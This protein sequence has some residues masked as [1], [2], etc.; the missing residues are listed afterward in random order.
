MSEKI[1]PLFK[2]VSIEVLTLILKKGVRFTQPQAF[3]DPFEF[4]PEM[5]IPLDS[6]G[7]QLNIAFDLAAP[8]RLPAV[9][10]EKDIPDGY[11]CSDIHSRHIVEQLNGIVGVLC[12]SRNP[13]SLLMWAHYADRYKGALIEFD[14]EDPFFEGQ[15]AVEYCDVRPR[16]NVSAYGAEGTMPLAELCVKSDKWEY[17]AEVRIIRNLSACAEKGSDPLYPVYV[18]QLPVNAI[19]EITLGE[20]CSVE[21]QRVIWDLVK[22]TEIGL[23]LAA[24]SNWGYEFRRERIK[25]RKP[26]PEM[27]PVLT[28][29]TAH[30]FSNHSGELGEFARWAIANHPMSKFVNRKA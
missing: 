30:I 15:I 13:G 27:T 24:V 3:N 6:D 4:L 12:L 8:R 17:E 10:R 25:Y 14:P 22:G 23:S 26:Y 11:E 5:C 9:G 28:P 29:R 18:Q 2:Y 19:K 20:R 7:S 16:I 1:T 21:D